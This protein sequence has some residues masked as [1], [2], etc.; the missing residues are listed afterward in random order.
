MLCNWTLGEVESATL[1]CTSLSLQ[2]LGSNLVCCFCFLCCRMY[3]KF[4]LSSD[5]RDI[6]I[7]RQLAAEHPN[8]IAQ[9]PKIYKHDKTGET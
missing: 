4:L 8:S 7:S 5:P 3:T 1:F 9:G 6:A 2:A